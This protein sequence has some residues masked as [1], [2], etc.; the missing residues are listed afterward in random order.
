MVAASPLPSPLKTQ[1]AAFAHRIA[2]LDR[3]PRPP[4]PPELNDLAA[5]LTITRRTGG[6][7][8]S[9]SHAAA[10]AVTATVLADLL[11]LAYSQRADALDRVR[12]YL[13]T[14]AVSVKGG[15]D[16]T[17]PEKDR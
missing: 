3:R 12:E 8:Q 15:P 17:A 7:H 5:L 13:G 11:P 14:L 4:K 6:S 2:T 16:F 1:F 9:P 10:A